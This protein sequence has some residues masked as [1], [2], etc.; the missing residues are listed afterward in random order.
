V[1]DSVLNV[2]G[3]GDADRG[4]RM[5]SLGGASL[6]VI[7]WWLLSTR[8]V[9]LPRLLGGVGAGVRAE[10]NDEPSAKVMARIGGVGR[11]ARA[12]AGNALRLR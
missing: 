2:V 6:I 1:A 7:G 8:A 12:R 9:P 4:A 3:L 10:G 5:A 11:F